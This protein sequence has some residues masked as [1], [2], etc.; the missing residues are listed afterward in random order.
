LAMMLNYYADY[1]EL[2]GKEVSYFIPG[3]V[4]LPLK[5]YQHAMGV[6]PYDST[7]DFTQLFYNAEQAQQAYGYL[8][9]KVYEL[10]NRFPDGEDYMDEYIRFMRLVAKEIK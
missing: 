10:G 4:I 9:K 2:V 1:D 3:R 6:L 5:F 8:K 7:N